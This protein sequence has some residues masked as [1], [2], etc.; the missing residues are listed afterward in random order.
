MGGVQ[1]AAGRG[2]LG[3]AQCSVAEVG[4]GLQSLRSSQILIDTYTFL[5]TEYI[6]LQEC[7]KWR[8]FHCPYGTREYAQQDA[9]PQQ[10]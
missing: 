9:D 1:G 8:R 4:V 7:H 5:L 6:R 10:D 3:W 2:L